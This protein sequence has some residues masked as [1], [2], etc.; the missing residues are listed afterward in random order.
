[1]SSYAKERT[2]LKNSIDKIVIWLWDEHDI[3]V[4]FDHEVDNEY[5]DDSKIISINSKLNYR[6]QLHTLLHEVGHFLLGIDKRKFNS[7][8]PYGGSGQTKN[9]RNRRVDTIRE[10]VYAWD[11][12]LEAAKQLGI[13]INKTSFNKHVSAAL[14]SYISWAS[15]YKKK[16]PKK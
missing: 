3:H 1:M 8:F 7:T 16:K 2:Y 5:D 13:R 14:W 4:D 9:G 12:G 10:E 6:V 15:S 11:K